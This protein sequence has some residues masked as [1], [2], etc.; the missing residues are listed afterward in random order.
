V[1]SEKKTGRVDGGA[2]AASLPQADPDVILGVNILI[3]DAALLGRAP[4]QKG[5]G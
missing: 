1:P 2:Y 3:K 4:P 5:R